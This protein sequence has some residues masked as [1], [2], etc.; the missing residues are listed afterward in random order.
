MPQIIRTAL[1]NPA[2][3]TKLS[4]IYTN[5]NLD[6]SG[7]HSKNRHTSMTSLPNRQ[8][9]RYGLNA[10]PTSQT[11]RSQC[12]RVTRNS[13]DLDPSTTKTTTT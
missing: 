6:E 9:R 8:Q 4:L 2:G 1:E 7:R 5:V 12:E 10:I 3:K 11:T 13:N